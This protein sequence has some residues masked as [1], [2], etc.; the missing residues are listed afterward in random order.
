MKTTKKRPQNERVTEELTRELL[1]QN[2][3]YIPECEQLTLPNGKRPEF[4]IYEKDFALV[5]ECKKTKS[6]LKDAVKEVKEYAEELAKEYNVIAVA[7]A[8]GTNTAFRS[9]YYAKDEV[10]NDDRTF[11][12]LKAESIIPFKDYREQVEQI[13]KNN[14]LNESTL[15]KKADE[16]NNLIRT[17]ADVGIQ[18]RSTLIAAILIAVED[19]FFRTTYMKKGNGELADYVYDTIESVLKKEKNFPMHKQQAILNEFHFLQTDINLSKE[20]VIE[21]KKTTSIKFFVSYIVRKVYLKLKENSEIDLLAEFYTEFFR[22]TSLSGKEL[23]IVLTPEHIKRFMARLVNVN[24]ADILLDTC[25]GTGGFLIT[26]LNM[27][28][29]EAETEEQ[30][31]D[32][33]SNRLIGVELKANMFLMAYASMRFHGDGKSNLY[34]GDSLDPTVVKKYEDR[35]NKCLINPPYSLGKKDKD[36]DE[37]NFVL[38]ALNSLRSHGMLAVII[39]VS[40]FIGSNKANTQWKEDIMAKHSLKAV[41]SMPEEIFDAG[42]VTAIGIFQAHVPHD[43]EE[44]VMLYDIENDG[45][46]TDRKEGRKDTGLWQAIEDEAAVAIKNKK[47]IKGKSISTCL[48]PTDEW[49][50]VAFAE[51]DYNELSKDQFLLNIVDYTIFENK[52]S[53]DE[54]KVKLFKTIENEDV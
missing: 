37:W 36:M 53:I 38:T 40:K 19:D 9:Y 48:S 16:L 29:N 21:G 10:D 54:L 11:I 43:K 49:L 27:M 50:Y 30:R 41:I 6:L 34:L 17:Y 39:P 31:D 1:K 22:R 35:A 42:T 46:I 3:D 18:K 23:G 47:E 2:G 26:A 5:I 7:V 14:E 4:V 28:L 15:K 51:P 44:T 25:T 52:I 13:E 32:I 45:F 20:K 33:K 12:S 24:K 8:G